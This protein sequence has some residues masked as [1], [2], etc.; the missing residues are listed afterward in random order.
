[1]LR[2]FSSLFSQGAISSF[3]LMI[4]QCDS[5]RRKC[6]CGPKMSAIGAGEESTKFGMLCLLSC[7]PNEQAP[8]SP[9]VSVLA[10]STVDSL[11]RTTSFSFL[12][13]RAVSAPVRARSP[14]RPQRLA[15][16]VGGTASAPVELAR[17]PGAA[18]ASS[19][20]SFPSSRSVACD[21]TLRV[22]R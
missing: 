18:A 8:A 20:D 5:W 19:R 10:R 12:P 2:G 4:W 16:S 6:D 22:P 9:S 21:A 3:A 14:L 1:M 17:E 13:P 7:V 15:Q 11:V